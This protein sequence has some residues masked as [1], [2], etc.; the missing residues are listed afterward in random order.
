MTTQ[1]QP[2][3]THAWADG[4]TDADLPEGGTNHYDESGRP[5]PMGPAEKEAHA[6]IWALIRLLLSSGRLG[7]EGEFKSGSRGASEEPGNERVIS[8]KFMLEG[9]FVDRREAGR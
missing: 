5:I 1:Q 8:W 2:A 7:L 9:R 3:P 4:K 6:H